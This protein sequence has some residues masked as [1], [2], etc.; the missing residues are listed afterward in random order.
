VQQTQHSYGAV[1]QTQARST[2]AEQR[3]KQGGTGRGPREVVPDRN[4]YPGPFAFQL[5]KA[6]LRKRQPVLYLVAGVSE[7]TPKC[8]FF[9]L[10]CSLTV[11]GCRRKVCYPRALSTQPQSSQNQ[12]QNQS[13]RPARNPLRCLGQGMASRAPPCLPRAGRGHSSVVAL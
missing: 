9:S 6:W 10:L 2:H 4:E 8:F 3:K 5:A 13:S 12:S 7:V 11:S 1:R